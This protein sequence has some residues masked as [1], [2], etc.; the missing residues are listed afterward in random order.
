M[1]DEEY[2]I[3]PDDGVRTGKMGMWIETAGPFVDLILHTGEAHIHMPMAPGLAR[4][5]S[6]ELVRCA[7]EAEANDRE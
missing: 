5:I 6:R 3:Q 2:K 4:K 1:N 7:R